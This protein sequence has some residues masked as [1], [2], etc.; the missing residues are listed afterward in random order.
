MDVATYQF[1]PL[2]LINLMAIVLPWLELVSGVMLVLGLRVRAAALLMTGMM[3]VFMIALG[4]ALYLGLDMSCGCFAS[5]GEADSISGLTM[6]RDAGWLAL[7]LYV[8]VFDGRPLGLE[9]LWRRR[10]APA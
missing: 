4:W 10:E 8:L 5:Q 3:L 6:W 7:C 1:L 2:P 9:L